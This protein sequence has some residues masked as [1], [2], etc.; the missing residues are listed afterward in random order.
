MARVCL[1]QTSLHLPPRWLDRLRMHTWMWIYAVS[2][3]NDMSCKW[4]LPTISWYGAIVQYPCMHSF[5]SSTHY[6]I[7]LHISCVILYILCL[8]SFTAQAIYSRSNYELLMLLVQF[9]LTSATWLP[10]PNRSK[11]TQTNSIG[12]ACGR[13][14]ETMH[15]PCETKGRLHYLL[16]NSKPSVNEQSGASTKLQLSWNKLVTTLPG[17]SYARL[18]SHY[19]LQTV[20]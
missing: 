13:R 12:T 16:L 19:S 11:V 5:T 9:Y 7:G 14:F 1:W 18:H 15:S 6:G 2:H 17:V 8:F 4:Q 3:N 10:P 20:L